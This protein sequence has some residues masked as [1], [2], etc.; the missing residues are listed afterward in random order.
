MPGCCETTVR[1]N[2]DIIAEHHRGRIKYYKIMV[3]IEVLA[4]S[5]VVTIVA[6]ERGLNDKF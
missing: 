4:M 2:K 1:P 3:G 6:P 5:D